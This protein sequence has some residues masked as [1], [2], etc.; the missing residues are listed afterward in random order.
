MRSYVL[1]KVDNA[2]KQERKI[3][4]LPM[5]YCITWAAGDA[6]GNDASLTNLRPCFSL[7]LSCRRAVIAW[8]RRSPCVSLLPP[9]TIPIP[10]SLA[11]ARSAETFIFLPVFCQDCTGYPRHAASLPPCA[12]LICV[13]SLWEAGTHDRTCTKTTSLGGRSNRDG[14]DERLQRKVYQGLHRRRVK[15]QNLFFFISFD[16]YQIFQAL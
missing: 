13:S 15:I 14:W 11:L 7:G 10:A 9:P 12:L 8:G 16:S 1:Q 5:V 3:H 6:K 4:A 2:G